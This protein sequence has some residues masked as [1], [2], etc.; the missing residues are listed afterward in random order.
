MEYKDVAK[1]I[2]DSLKIVY[3][4]FNSI[5]ER[6]N[7]EYIYKKSIPYK[8][9]KK[10]TLKQES[11]INDLFKNI[12]YPIF[13]TVFPMIECGIVEYVLGDKD[14][15]EDKLSNPKIIEEGM[16]RLY[17]FQLFR[18]NLNLSFIM[19]LYLFVEQNLVRLFWQYFN[20][21]SNS[22][23]ELINKIDNE[24]KFDS[25]IKDKINIYKDVINVFKHGYGSSYNSLLKNHKDLLN[26]HNIPSTKNNDF[27]FDINKISLNELYC[28]FI[29]FL[30]AIIIK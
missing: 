18:Y 5:L 1:H 19:Q 25:R 3:T 4:E 2:K 17:S 11:E 30:N 10:C 9:S 6:Y 29:E 22:I 14:T 7:K 28:T 13:D 12:Y 8:P 15:E 20:I 24:L 16:D 21:E 27:I 23:F 26:Q